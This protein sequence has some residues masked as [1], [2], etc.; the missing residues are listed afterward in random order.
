MKGF[1]KNGKFI[2]TGSKSKSNLKKAD[3]RNKKMFHSC[4]DCDRA[5][6]EQTER[7]NNLKRNKV[8]IAEGLHQPTRDNGKFTPLTEEQ[9]QENIDALTEDTHPLYV[10]MVKQFPNSS[11]GSDI[12]RWASSGHYG[13]HGGFGE[14]LRSGNIEGAMFHADADNLEYLG[15]LGIEN[16]LSDVKPHELDP[17]PRK[18]FQDR[19]RWASGRTQEERDYPLGRPTV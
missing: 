19:H 3:I 2:P 4:P 9:K 17:S 6:R 12:H 11:V 1:K 15:E 10:Q 7:A 16:H 13:S 14:K 5:E 18:E 8:T